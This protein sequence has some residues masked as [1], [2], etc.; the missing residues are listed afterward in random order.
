[1]TWTI[2]LDLDR[3]D[4]S[5]QLRH[6][7]FAALRRLYEAIPPLGCAWEPQEMRSG[8]VTAYARVSASDGA[9]ITVVR[10]KFGKWMAR[11]GGVYVDGDN[12]APGE[13]SN[14]EAA[15]LAA[16]AVLAAKGYVLAPTE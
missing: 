5:L 3:D 15:M 2:D 7:D 1:M 10:R 4:L 11:V 8:M 9:T 6:V 13:W 12:G 14:R 16:D